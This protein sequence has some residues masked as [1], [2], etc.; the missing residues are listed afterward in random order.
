MTTTPPFRAEQVGSTH[1]G[2]T[3]T[4]DEQWR[5]VERVVEVARLVWGA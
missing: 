4:E 2:N 1:H 5:K 3:L